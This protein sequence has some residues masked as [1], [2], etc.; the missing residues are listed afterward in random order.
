MM[1]DSIRAV[2]ESRDAEPD[3]LAFAARERPWAV[4]QRAI[5]IPVRPHHRGML[6]VDLDDVVGI[7]NSLGWLEFVLGNVPDECHGDLG[8]ESRSL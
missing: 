6:G 7:G 3:H 1:V 5:Q 8:G 4:H 2:I